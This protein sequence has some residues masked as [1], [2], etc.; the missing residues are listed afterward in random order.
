MAQKVLQGPL[1]PEAES[2]VLR[3]PLGFQCKLSQGIEPSY[4][5]GFKQSERQHFLIFKGQNSI[6]IE[7]P[8]QLSG[9]VHTE[10]LN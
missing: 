3:K 5:T 8:I 2:S 6:L 1:G 10:Y 4:V 7:K 9:K